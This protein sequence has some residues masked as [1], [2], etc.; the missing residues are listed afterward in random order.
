MKKYYS[1]LDYFFFFCW[2]KDIV[3][4]KKV[5]ACEQESQHPGSSFPLPKR[6]IGRFV[7]RR[8][9]PAFLLPSFYVISVPIL[10]RYVPPRRRVPLSTPASCIGLYVLRKQTNQYQSLKFP[11]LHGTFHFKWDPERLSRLRLKGKR[12]NYRAIT[13]TEEQTFMRSTCELFF[14]SPHLIADFSDLFW[15]IHFYL[16]RQSMRFPW[17]SKKCVTDN[18]FNRINSID[19]I[20][21]IC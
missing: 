10:T 17:F 12:E 16:P 20:K 21:N 14:H 1:Y 3:W 5:R 8:I 6:S 18:C 4:S 9:V 15:T 7:E 2:T 11:W 19:S 13:H